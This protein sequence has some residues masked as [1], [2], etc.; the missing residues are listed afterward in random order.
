MIKLTPNADNE[1]GNY[2]GPPLQTE[3]DPLMCHWRNASFV[4]RC[5]TLSQEP[6]LQGNFCLRRLN[7]QYT[8][9]PF[10]NKAPVPG[11]CLMLQYFT[12]TNRCLQHR[13]GWGSRV[14]VS[15]VSVCILPWWPETSPGSSASLRLI[16]TLAS[17]GWEACA[18][19]SVKPPVQLSSV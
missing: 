7:I 16:N 10:C 6:V 2:H 11:I 14:A 3:A 19:G 13:E 5:R 17:W 4:E 1:G 12:P 8:W 9:L 15:F 18:R